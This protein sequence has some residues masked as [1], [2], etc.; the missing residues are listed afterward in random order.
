MWGINIVA[1]RLLLWAFKYFYYLSSTNSTLF[2]CAGDD[3][4][5]SLGGIRCTQ[6]KVICLRHGMSILGEHSG[7]ERFSSLVTNAQMAQKREWTAVMQKGKPTELVTY[8]W[9]PISWYDE[10]VGRN[11]FIQIRLKSSTVRDLILEPMFDPLQFALLLEFQS[12]ENL[13]ISFTRQNIGYAWFQV[14]QFAF[15]PDQM[16]TKEVILFQIES[17]SPIHRSEK[18]PH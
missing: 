8:P 10:V 18:W 6:T 16:E 12:C 1:F 7:W 3:G 13:M 15:R 17:M 5:W 2:Q 4:P 14:K 11:D 9:R